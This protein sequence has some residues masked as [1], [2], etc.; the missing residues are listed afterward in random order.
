[1]RHS[2]W[3]RCLKRVFFYMTKYMHI[4]YTKRNMQSVLKTAT[5]NL[6]RVVFPLE[7]AYSVKTNNLLA[8]IRRAEEVLTTYKSEIQTLKQD[9]E[10]TNRWLRMLSEEDEQ[11]LSRKKY[12]MQIYKNTL[13]SVNMTPGVY[14]MKWTMLVDWFTSIPLGDAYSFVW[15]CADIKMGSQNE[16]TEATKL[17]LRIAL[18][19]KSDVHELYIDVSMA[20]L[21]SRVVSSNVQSSCEL[22]FAKENIL[23]LHLSDAPDISFDLY[24]ENLQNDSANLLTTHVA[25]SYAVLNEFTKKSS[26]KRGKRGKRGR[27]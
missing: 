2:Y 20:A 8:D 14:L 27:H 1:V 9:L 11:K 3:R 7:T 22:V 21:M 24:S 16:H 26:G 4:Q 25:D 18:V 17:R 5:Q 12:L 15:L 13:K 10:T 6:F 19:D 23:K